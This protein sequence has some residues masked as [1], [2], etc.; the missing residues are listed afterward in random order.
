MPITSVDKMRLTRYLKEHGIGDIYYLDMCECLGKREKISNLEFLKYFTDCVVSE[1][2]KNDKISVKQVVKLISVVEAFTI[3][4]H[5]E[6]QTIEE[7]LLDKIRSFK[8]FYDEY[9]NNNQLERDNDI[10]LSIDTTLKTVGELFPTTV[11][12]DSVSKYINQ[13][14][15]L[16]VQIKKLEKELAE[17][18]RLYEN[19]QQSYAK[20]SEKADNLYAETVSLGK[21]IRSKDK[22]IDNLIVTIESLKLKIEELEEELSKV[23]LDN[24]TLFGYKEKYEELLKE[25][26]LLRMKVAQDD[27]SR[28]A[29]IK[30]SLKETKVETL[31][32]QKLLFE[33]ASL[34]DIVKYIKENKIATSREEVANLLKRVKSVINISTSSFS[35]NPIYKVEQPLIVEDEVFSINVPFNCKYYD[36][37]LVSDLHI[38][39]FDRKTLHGFEALN[40]Y[41]VNYGIN[42]ILDLGDFY[43]GIGT[44]SLEY[45]NAVKNYKLAEEA[46]K[47]IPKADGIYHAILGGNHDQ[48]ITSYGFDPIRVL[49][50][51]RE[52]FLHLGYNHSVISLNNPIKPLGHFDIHH[53]HT[54]D[55]PIRLDENGIDLG[56]INQYL[57]EVYQRQGRSRDDS[58]I[59]LIGHTHKSQFNYLGSYYFLPPYLEGG[60]KKGACHL[61]IYFDEDSEI[62]Y[63]VFMPLSFSINKLFQNNE[64]VYQK[65]LSK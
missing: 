64:I 9:L 32:Y 62:K 47:I 21:D 57:D 3:W 20:K 53:P 15:N 38:K 54:F 44:K 8:E 5:E 33:G 48:N 25:A 16:E 37:M 7:E 14:S 12:A 60:V 65:V 36:I 41:C 49:T 24:S 17:M 1:F 46:V 30:T 56:E 40:N 35:L 4:T 18:T 43:Q 29:A 19:L 34:D 27:A 50:G 11:K 13:I 31:I 2:Q 42:L 45:E 23:K 58:Y 6:G 26:E 59:D 39:E 52:D 63:M 61:R 55:F 22:D 28:R 51:E 10:A